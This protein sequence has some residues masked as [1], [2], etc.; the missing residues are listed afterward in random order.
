MAGVTKETASSA[1]LNAHKHEPP[2]TAHKIWALVRQQ[3]PIYV[4]LT[5]T[6]LTL[7][8]DSAWH[9]LD[10]SAYVPATVFMVKLSIAIGSGS[11]FITLLTGPEGATSAS[12]S[13]GGETSAYAS[14]YGENKFTSFSGQLDQYLTSQKL[15]YKLTEDGSGA[16]VS[17]IGYWKK[18]M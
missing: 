14:P 4:P 3:I 9:N 17:I 18:G 10:I 6:A 7:T 16:V 13:W 11:R 1:D 2:T 12:N 8:N 5:P 15:A